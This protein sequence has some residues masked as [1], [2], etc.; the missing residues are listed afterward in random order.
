MLSLSAHKFHGPKGVGA[1]YIRAGRHVRAQIIGG[2]QEQGLR[3]GTEN[4]AGIVGMGAAAELAAR[5]PAEHMPRVRRMRDQLETGI[6]ER[7]GIAQVN[8]DREH[9]LPNTTNIGFRALESQAILVLLSENGVCASGGAACHS[10]S[11]EASHVLKAMG[12]DE[13][14]AHGAVRFS[15]SRYSTMDEIDSVLERLPSLIS[16]LQAVTGVLART[17]AAK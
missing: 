5:S 3:G 16:R 13:H 15:L 1:L 14:V 11:L 12:I 2:G 17:D 6:C 7:I 10:G 4:V 9:R 8:G